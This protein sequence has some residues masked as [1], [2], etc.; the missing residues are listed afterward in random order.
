MNTIEIPL[1]CTEKKPLLE[2]NGKELVLSGLMPYGVKMVLYH[3]KSNSDIQNHYA[4]RLTCY[5]MNPCN[6]FDTPIHGDCILYVN[7]YE[8]IQNL[9][10]QI[11]LWIDETIVNKQRRTM[12]ENV[13]LWIEKRMSY[14]K[15]RLQE[16]NLPGLKNLYDHLNISVEKYGK[17]L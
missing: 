9:E 2:K 16:N 7:S 1:Y 6:I 11:K 17:Y 3:C 4:T 13:K 14:I 5:C 10:E 12:P 8:P 15:E